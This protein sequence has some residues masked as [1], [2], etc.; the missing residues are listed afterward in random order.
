[1]VECLLLFSAC[2]LACDLFS[3]GDG[4]YVLCCNTYGAFLCD[5]LLDLY[6]R[7]QNYELA[8]FVYILTLDDVNLHA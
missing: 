8:V 6:V 5:D 4:I 1:M 7:T 2:V 3:W